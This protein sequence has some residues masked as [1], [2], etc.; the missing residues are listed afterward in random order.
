MKQNDLH[1]IF[2]VLIIVL[3]AVVLFIALRDLENRSI[4]N[5][6]NDN[7]VSIED[8]DKFWSIIT[9]ACAKQGKIPGLITETDENNWQRVN[10]GC[11]DK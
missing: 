8:R 2:L 5:R 10:V 11:K 3:S 1:P 9:E 6:E 4:V 7:V